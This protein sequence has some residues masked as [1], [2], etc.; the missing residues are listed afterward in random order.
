MCGK[1]FLCEYRAL[2]EKYGAHVTSCGCCEGPYVDSLT[3]HQKHEFGASAE[4][5][6][7]EHMYHLGEDKSKCQ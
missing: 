7:D 5:V 6:L 3:R 2:C 4:A 1:T